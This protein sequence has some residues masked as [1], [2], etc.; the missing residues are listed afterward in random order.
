MEKGVAPRARGH[1]LQRSVLA[2]VRRHSGPTQEGWFLSLEVQPIGHL[3]QL[4]SYHLRTYVSDV[5]LDKIMSKAPS[6]SEWISWY[7]SDFVYK[8]IFSVSLAITDFRS[9]FAG[10]ACPFGNVPGLGDSRKRYN[11]RS[12]AFFSSLMA[13]WILFSLAFPSLLFCASLFVYRM[14][15]TFLH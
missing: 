11:Y 14:G 9:T 1:K 3:A 12:K 7:F 8:F 4:S 5:G 2:R 6:N 15:E 10:F 13:L